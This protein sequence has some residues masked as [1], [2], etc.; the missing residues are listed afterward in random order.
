MAIINEIVGTSGKN[1][2]VT[3]SFRVSLDERTK[4]NL[5]LLEDKILKALKANNFLLFYFVLFS[6]RKRVIFKHMTLVLNSVS[7]TDNLEF[8]QS[9]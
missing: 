4:G 9:S 3:Q 1:Y 6:N 2:K 8:I 5:K 7:I